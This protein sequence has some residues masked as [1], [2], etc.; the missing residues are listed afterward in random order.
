M[1]YN[2]PS[3]FIHKDIYKKN[4]YNTELRVFSDYELILKIF[5]RD[6]NLFSYIPEAYVNYRIDGISSQISIKEKIKEGY[7]SRKK[8]GQSLP[9]NSGKLLVL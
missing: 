2:H 3:M 9:V 1:T 8:A 6:K 7:I 4:R 5:L